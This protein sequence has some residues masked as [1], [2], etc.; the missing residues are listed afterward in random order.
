MI[1]LMMEEVL[2]E[3]YGKLEQENLLPFDLENLLLEASRI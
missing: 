2:H 3:L 1:P